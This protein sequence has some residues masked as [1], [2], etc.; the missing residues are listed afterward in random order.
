MSKIKSG[1]SSKITEDLDFGHNP[2][3][4]NLRLLNKDGSLNIIRKGL[5]FF[6][7]HEAYN[8][9]IYMS[10][11]KFWSVVFISYLLINILFALIYLFIGVEH[12]AGQTGITLTDQFFDCLFF[13]AQ[14][15]STV[16]YGHLSPE[17]FATSVVAAIESMLGLLAFA[18]ATGLLYGRFSRPTSKIRYSKNILVAPYNGISAYIFRLANLRSNKL[19]DL[20][21]NVL[22][23]INVKEDGEIIRK[24]T[25]LDLERNEVNM[26]SLSWTVIHPLSDDSPLKGLTLKDL[27][28][29]EAEII[30]MLKAFDDGFS[31][32]V[33]SRTLYKAQEIIFDATFEQIMSTDENGVVELDM[34]KISKYVKV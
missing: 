4:N 16:G 15:L 3:E 31:Q 33:H 27:I 18:L 19:I 30:V 29:G 14:T 28:D 13:S 22:L 34:G 12:I 8:S 5:P 9:L 6:K 26:L 10:W 20:T 17:G 24:F 1:R 7:P 2:T 21:I 23:S 32:I 11:K 25:S